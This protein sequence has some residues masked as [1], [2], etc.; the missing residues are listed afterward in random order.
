MREHPDGPAAYHLRTSIFHDTPLDRAVVATM[1]LS[2][3]A[4]R[5]AQQTLGRIRQTWLDVLNEEIADPA[6]A[7]AVLLMGDGLYFAAATAG[8]TDRSSEDIEALIGVV[9]SLVDS[10]R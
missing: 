4:N 8:V 9:R 6:I 7:E 10:R 5:L 3:G 2:Q 1:R